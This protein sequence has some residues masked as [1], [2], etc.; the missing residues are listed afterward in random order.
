MSFAT[1]DPVG[2]IGAGNQGVMMTIRM[3]AGFEQQGITA[4]R[5]ERNE[6]LAALPAEACALLDPHLTD[7]VLTRGA[8]LHDHGDPLGHI[9]FIQSGIVCLLVVMPDGEAVE[10]ATVGREGAVGSEVAIGWQLAPHRAMVQ[11]PVRAARIAA[12]RFIEAMQRNAAL[13]RLITGHWQSLVLQIQ[14]I[15][16][17]NAMHGA[18]ARLC[19][20]LLHAEQ[21]CGAV[22]AI[23]QETLSHL[24]GVQ[25]TT[26]N[27]L[28]RNLQSEGLIRL[29]RGSVEIRDDVGLEAK[30]CCCYRTVRASTERVIPDAHEAGVGRPGSPSE[31]VHHFSDA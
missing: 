6:L 23:T 22:V 2:A 20:W 8:V 28:C 13:R 4:A 21:R 11:V 16:A 30:A 24:L 9:Y 31:A 25:R 12:P 7:V 1:H 5:L 14:Q 10:V 18:E 3:Q 27:M 29:G 15:A 17:C 26:V 19:R